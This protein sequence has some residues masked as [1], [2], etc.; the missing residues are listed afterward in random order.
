[1]DLAASGIMAFP[2]KKKRS[3]SLP[4]VQR[5]AGQSIR[6]EKERLFDDRLTPYLFG[7][8]LLWM[9]YLVESSHS[10]LNQPP[11][12]RFWLY[13]ASVATAF[14]WIGFRRL[15]PK[16]RNLNRGERG[17]LKVAEA[18]DELRAA[19]YQTFHDVRGDGYNIDHVVVGPAGVFAVE[20]KYRSGFGEI[21][22]RDG[23]G[24]FVGGRKEEDDPLKQARR[25]AN[26]VNRM[27]KENCG[28]Y[29]WV[30]PLVVF[31]GDH[32]IKD[33]W[34]DTDARVFTVDQ[35]ARYI[36]EQQPELK[37]SEIQLISSHLKRT[38]RS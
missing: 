9:I 28:M 12:P 32:K 34:R 8:G 7:P 16:F 18:L 23:E 15:L 3:Q 36:H 10:W 5:T 17:E 11:Q 31:V 29:Q 27:I 37:R 19:G 22:F 20:T 2:G 21:E 38:V 14:S 6:D 26:D 1:M 35:V 4:Q 13:L 33:T 24:L 30:K 25:N